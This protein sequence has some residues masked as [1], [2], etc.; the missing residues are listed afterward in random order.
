M[1]IEFFGSSESQL[2]GTY[3]AARSIE[4]RKAIVVCPPVGQEY[5]R[6]HWALKLLAK[7]LSRKGIHAL[8]FDYRGHGDSFGDI[9]DVESIDEWKM[10]LSRAVD[11]LKQESGVSRVML[12]GLRVGAALAAEVARERTDVHSLV[13][14]EPIANGYDYLDELRRVHTTMIDLWFQK[15][16]TVNNADGEEI[17]GWRYQ[18]SLL[19]EIESWDV[20]SS[21]LAIPQLRI[22]LE[23]ALSPSANGGNRLLK[24][25]GVDDESVWGKL[26]GL[27]SAWLRPKT[28]QLIVKAVNDMFERLERR[29]ML[30]T[31]D[32]LVQTGAY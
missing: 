18:R 20:D 2:L 26:A 12:M 4:S 7:Q 8:R 5:I 29:N 11:F 17:L 9:E 1:K 24:S 23:G 6:T 3:H 22:E 30:G 16:A 13:S 19:N 27:E 21:S 31:T 25:I 28:T 32:R 15:V 10:D 14:W